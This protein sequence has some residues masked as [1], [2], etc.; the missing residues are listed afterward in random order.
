MRVNPITESCWKNF[1]QRTHVC[2]GISPFNS[3]FT[4]QRIQEL[5]QWGREEFSSMHFFVPD[6][7]SA[8]TLEALGYD[9]EKAAWK[10]RR[11]C[12]YLHNKIQRALGNLG[13]SL[14]DASGMVLNWA[15]LSAN[16]RFNALYEE[17]KALFETDQKFQG[18][19]IEASRWILEKR[20]PDEDALTPEAL[21]SAAR[22][23]LA[24]IP[25]FLD[26]AGIVGQSASVFCYHQT[27]SF[28]ENLFHG[29]LAIRVNEKQ[30]FVR[31]TPRE[32]ARIETGLQ[33][34]AEDRPDAAESL[35]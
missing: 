22:Y 3:Y 25:L 32:P 1:E 24:E 8:Y 18:A 13:Y 26:S 33:I 12:Q 6:V 7:P 27:V 10:A 5:A 9:T 23:L 14:R 34:S 17:V 35:N 19:C 4:E 28:I 15:N 30:G 2:F 21:R 11:Q 20:V 29:S 16:P 31:I